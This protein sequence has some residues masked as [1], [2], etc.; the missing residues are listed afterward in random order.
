MLRA[1]TM[2]S[3]NNT[4]LQQGK[5]RFHG[6]C[7]D[8]TVHVNLKA[9]ADR[10]VF[11]LL[12]EMPR[13]AAIYIE[14]VGH[15]YVN[16]VRDVFAD[17]LFECPSLNVLGVEESQLAL[18]LANSDYD[19]LVRRSASS[20]S[21]SLSANVGF[22]H[23]DNSAERL[24]IRFNHRS[25][26]SVAEVPRGFVGFDSERPLNLTGRHSFLGLAEQERGEKP[27]NERQVRVVEDS[28]YG[29]AELVLA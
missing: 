16:V 23:L 14:I 7:V 3:A 9:V 8:V 10:L 6:V 18:S 22:I 17:V 5:G 25:A 13:R 19:F 12:T 4:A 29:H 21:V 20:F 11:S 1:N 2:P 27:R 28:V 26:D 15:Q 24:A